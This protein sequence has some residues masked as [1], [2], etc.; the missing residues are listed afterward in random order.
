V[1]QH[2]TRNRVALG[3]GDIGCCRRG[4][5]TAGRR[6]VNSMIDKSLP[7]WEVGAEPSVTAV[8]LHARARLII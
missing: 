2:G 6:V 5:L 1:N 4:V 8:A 7:P 3:L